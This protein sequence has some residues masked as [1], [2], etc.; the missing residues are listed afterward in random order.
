MHFL[1]AGRRISSAIPLGNE[2]E[3]QTHLMFARSFLVSKVRTLISVLAASW[4][5]CTARLRGA[6]GQA[7]VAS[8]SE[9]RKR[10][11]T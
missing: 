8:Q 1:R 5:L 4:Y 9:Q 3:R 2:G 10:G 6:K 11:R 7:S